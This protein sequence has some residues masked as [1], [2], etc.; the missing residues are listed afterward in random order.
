M[1]N[2]KEFT[3]IHEFFE[4]NP[5]KIY[6]LVT[7]LDVNIKDNA[8]YFMA[9]F[10]DINKKNFDHILIPPELLRNKYK[11]G[12]YYKNGNKFSIPNEIS[13][14]N[15]EIDIEIQI[16]VKNEEKNE[17]VNNSTLI[18][19]SSLFGKEFIFD[20]LDKYYKGF[21]LK[22]WSFKID[23][24]DYILIIPSYA[25]LL[26]YYLLSTSMK[27]AVMRNNLTSLY[28]GIYPITSDT[29]NIH[30]KRNANKKDLPFLCRFLYNPDIPQKIRELHLQSIKTSLKFIQIKS[31]FPVSGKSN[32]LV[33]CKLLDIQIDEKPVIYVLNILND[34]SE[35]GFSKLIYKQ[36]SMGDNPANHQY[37]EI[38]VPKKRIIRRKKSN[39]QDNVIRIGTPSNENSIEFLYEKVE[40]DFNTL[41][42]EVINETIYIPSSNT[43]IE[44]DFTNNKCSNSFETATSSGDKNLSQVSYSEKDEENTI[45]P[46]FSLKDFL[47]FYEILLQELG[48]EEIEAPD[49][50]H[51]EQ[52]KNSKQ[53]SINSKCIN[54]LTK[55]E[56]RFMFAILE[57]NSK[58]IYIIEFERD[59][60]WKPS[61]WLFISEDIEEENDYYDIETFKSII[62]E[63]ISNQLTYDKLKDYCNSEYQLKM[64]THNHKNNV[65]D[66][67][68]I[69]DWCENLLNKINFI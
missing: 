53:S 66:D 26:R 52:I 12:Y 51:I 25:V 24:Q 20:N 10:K 67:D 47:D 34:D 41:N 6:K 61:T 40:K 2:E 43:R 22:Q 29:A 14:K 7:I 11:I 37:K 3:H 65:I 17:K 35:L 30:I 31:Y 46:I 36:Y 45:T 5:N 16:E 23:M 56:R 49:L 32:I 44:Y 50:F 39:N 58:V 60:S 59:T 57:Y 21:F 4:K 1:Q 9:V 69:E 42:L 38:P 63:Y 48:V 54:I 33:N 64:I 28:H 62:H 13:R 8:Y 15:I 18:Q 19:N 27:N 55:S 68:S